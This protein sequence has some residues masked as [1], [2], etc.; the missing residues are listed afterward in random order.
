MTHLSP[1]LSY[2]LAEMGFP[3]NSTYLAYPSKM[4]ISQN[5]FNPIHITH[6][7]H[8]ISQ[9]PFKAILFHRAHLRHFTEPLKTSI[10]VVN[11]QMLIEESLPTVK[12]QRFSLRNLQKGKGVH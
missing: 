2:Y 4:V 9:N 10:I 5:P 12:N 3:L 6:L 8:P 11:Y 1:F 7:G